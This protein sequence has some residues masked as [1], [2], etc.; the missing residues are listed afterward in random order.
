MH[1]WHRQQELFIELEYSGLT[2]KIP[3][4]D[5]RI[6]ASA[7]PGNAELRH[8][9]GRNIP[10]SGCLGMSDVLVMA[11]SREEFHIPSALS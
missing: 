5:D 9:Q 10:Y 7:F 8:L 3:T 2:P 4:A 6:A 1:S 11:L